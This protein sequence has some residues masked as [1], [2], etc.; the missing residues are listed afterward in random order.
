MIQT[1]LIF[2]RRRTQW[3]SYRAAAAVG[4]LLTCMVAVAFLTAPPASACGPFFTDAIFVFT[5]HPDFPLETFAA[6]KL[7]VV[8]PTWA[9]SYL[10]AAYRNLSGAPLSEP[11]AKGIKAL[12]DA[13]L[14]LGYDA[15]D[16]DWVKNWNEARKK[17][18]GAPAAPEVRAYRNREKPN[19]YESFLNCQQDAFTNAEAILNERI[20]RFG[21]DSAQVRSWLAAQDT[22]FMNCGGGR[23]IPPE[24]S[25]EAPD[26]PPLLRADRAYQIAAAN[27]YSTNFD[28]AKQLFDAIAK[29]KD[30]PYREMA[31]YVAARA[32]LRKGSLAE[33]KESASPSLTDS[34]NRLNAILKD[35]SL[36]RVHP[37]AAR[38]LNLVRLRLHP[39]TKLHE[40][41][42]TIVKR[43]ASKDFRQ[44]VWDYTVLMD[45]FLGDESSDEEPS[46]KPA[47][48]SLR[49]DDL[50]DWIVT[51]EDDSKEAAAHALQR[52]ERGSSLPWL[53]AAISKAH[54]QSGAAT[55]NSLLG[56]ARAVGNDSPAFATLA[57]HSA[58]LLVESGRADEARTLLD[59]VLTNDRQSLDA[60]ATNSLMGQRVLLAQ[61]LEQFLQ[62]AQRKP[63]AFSDD[64]DGREIP[65]EESELTELTKGAKLFFDIN[66][67][68]VF[69]K[70]MP[71]AVTA[72]AARS[73]TLTTNLRRDVTQAAFVRAALLDDREAANQTATM[74]PEFYPELREFLTA[75]QR[76][77]TPEARRF[78]AVF[79]AL[80]FP[81]VRP[82]VSA[83]IGRTSALSEIDSYRDNYWCAE[84]P[85]P[86]GG[87]PSEDTEATKRK[88]IAVPE[89]L[90]PSQ[91]LAAREFATL[92][93]LGIAPNYFSRM[94]IEWTEKNPTDPRSPEALHLAVRS[95]RYGCT[96][97][98]TGRWSK[99]A[100]DL[101][102]RKYPN[103]TWAR[104]TK[105]WFKG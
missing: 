16:E 84:A 47:P 37:A 30:S 58:R 77:A 60:S 21:A 55:I 15:G 51:I 22:V 100:F 73:K 93:G 32:M 19:E 45:K 23:H 92:Q 56:K 42:H 57:Y 11:E 38:L 75:Y 61:N 101:L 79:L 81:G 18:P 99:A 29:D 50:S 87:D 46:P 94:A 80:K 5:K 83:G 2:K 65:G 8:S 66:T 68:N 4:F 36:N 78:A 63:T 96:D 103:T 86:A 102:H 41:A 14:N 33:N 34:E 59:K 85:I 40:I 3:K 76:A 39:E 48:P 13:R 35:T 82:Y 104:N 67:A 70:A 12:W 26:L 49:T 71:V 44:D 9:R 53:V 62:F 10:V 6:G 64:D 72:D 105:Y 74:L 91:S 31:A 7:G 24:A 97:K 28:E 27:F 88:P 90:K 95:T 43:D 69:N 52:F 98:D 54:G 25:T 1:K 17:V 20:A 89:F